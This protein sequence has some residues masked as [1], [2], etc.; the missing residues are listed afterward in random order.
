MGGRR[1]VVVAAIAALVG[2]LAAAP[3]A[4]ASFHEI[5]IRE[6]YPGS[7]AQP[8]SDYVELQ[9]YAAGQ[10]FVGGYGITVYG[11]N[12]SVAGTFTF[13]SS[14]P[15]G[16]NQQ[17]ILVGDSGVQGAFGVAPDLANAN[18]AID[19]AGGAAC[20]AG[21]IDCVSW[22]GFSGSTPSS[23]GTPAAVSGIPDG[24]ALR[25]SIAPGC[26][27]LLEV[28]DD[29]NSSSADLFDVSPSP[30]NNASAIAETTCT[31][32]ATTIDTKPADP[33]NSTSAAFTYHAAS[34]T[35]FAC[36]LDSASFADCP[37]NGKSY[38]GPLGDGNHTFQIRATN[39]SGFTGATAG[40]TW[41]VDT[42]AP[43]VTI[44]SHPTDPSSGTSVSFKYHSSESGSSFQCSLAQGAVPDS[45]SSCTS[46]GKT[47]TSLADDTYTFKVRATD[48]ATNQGAPAAFSWTVDHTAVDTT[49]PDTVIDSAPPNPSGDSTASFTYH[50][51]E[52]GSSF[53]CKLDGAAFA[54]CPATGVTY[55]GLANGSHA[56]QV[57]AI[58]SSANVD[59][60]PAGYSFDV[61]V[62]ASPQPPPVA[63]TVA[64]FV[65]SLAPSVTTPK[66]HH[67]RCRRGKHRRTHNRPRRCRRVKHPQHRRPDA[68]SHRPQ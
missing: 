40:Y 10:N 22:G 45:F 28:A 65:P 23:S 21:S 14:L 35:S 30:R 38:P 68:R 66:K 51:T 8:D 15:N 3:A 63:P 17:T 9:M 19:P 42:L 43:T 44:D 31:G 24:M 4:Q 57:R 50:A 11:A 67:R 18:F 62:L 47:Y 52:P 20:W 1:L 13:P 5:S 26:P 6:V 37:L 61:A 56:F 46:S 32:P 36:R 2:V 34:A 12:G 54:S 25:R 60:A 49:P 53:Q 59:P 41:R 33:T 39:S 29:S 48:T 64:P 55:M 58:D 16:A 7:V 27:T